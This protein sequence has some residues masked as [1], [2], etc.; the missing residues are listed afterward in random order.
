MRR[1]AKRGAR[2]GE[3]DGCG[4]ERDKSSEASE[5][6]WKR[7]GGSKRKVCTGE[8]GGDS[9]SV[10][11]G[12]GKRREAPGRK[13]GPV[14]AQFL[15]LFRPLPFRDIALAAISR[16]G[17]AKAVPRRRVPPERDRT[18]EARGIPH[19][20]VAVDW[21]SGRLVPSV[22]A[23]PTA[24]LAEGNWNRI[25]SDGKA[26]VGVGITRFPRK[27]SGQSGPS[28][29]VPWASLRHAPKRSRHFP[30]PLPD[31]HLYPGFTE[32][33]WFWTCPGKRRFYILLKTW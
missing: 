28:H 14:T 5:R 24:T 3:R 6:Y 20:P 22:H 23:N 16:E 13:G 21:P 17:Q 9:A 2:E 19:A 18:H 25:C 7:F 1:R 10:K 30:N 26:S 31:R 11:T 29:T 4:C 32:Q 15:L 8:A 33:V 27:I 12:M